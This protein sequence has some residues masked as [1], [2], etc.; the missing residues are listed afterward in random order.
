ME[1]GIR[2]RFFYRLMRTAGWMAHGRV[3]AASH[4]EDEKYSALSAAGS[5]TKFRSELGIM[6]GPVNQNGKYSLIQQNSLRPKFSTNSCIDF[7]HYV[8]K[9]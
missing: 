5:E 1:A 9:I 4:G 2:G 3:M 8:S 6:R 7:F